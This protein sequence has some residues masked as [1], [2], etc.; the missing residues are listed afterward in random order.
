MKRRIR[1]TDDTADL[2]KGLH[3]EIKKKIKAGLEMILRSPDA[4]K[5]LKDELKGLRSLKVG[6]FR[7]IYRLCSSDIVE[8]VAIGPRRIIYEVTYELIRKEE[9]G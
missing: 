8:I 5:S 4:G 3:P 2:M 9:K 1:V 7:V 6:R